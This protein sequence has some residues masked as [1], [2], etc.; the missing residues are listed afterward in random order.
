MPEHF[1]APP[2]WEWWI[3]AYFFFGGIAGGSYAIG[4]LIRLVGSADDQRIARLAFI[5]SFVALIPCPL[6]LIA[7]LGVPT[8]FIN[9][10]IDASD[11]GLA[12]KYWSPISV[13][14]Y[15]L[16]GFG[17]GLL[18]QCDVLGT[19]LRKNKPDPTVGPRRSD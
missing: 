1:A 6:F 19:L 4:T 18:Q 7:D 12:F 15:A 13:G 16:L 17:L 5:V 14:S 9:M 11:G 10:L 8:R 2:N 3:L